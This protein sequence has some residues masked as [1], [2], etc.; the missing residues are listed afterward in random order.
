[1][2]PSLL[3]SLPKDCR[4]SNAGVE[5]FRLSFGQNALW[6]ARRVVA[7]GLFRRS[8]EVWGKGERPRQAGITDAG[9]SCAYKNAQSLFTDVDPDVGWQRNACHVELCG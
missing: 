5:E 7:G 9:Y 6:Y 8:L 4:R 1:M 2:W 3:R